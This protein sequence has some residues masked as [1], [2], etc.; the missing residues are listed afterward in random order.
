MSC[1]YYINDNLD[2]LP[3]HEQADHLKSCTLCR[4]R[5]EFED[6]IVQ[7]AGRLQPL[8]ADTALWKRIDNSIQAKNTSKGIHKLR[9]GSQSKI[10]LSAAAV[11][12]AV[13]TFSVFYIFSGGSEKILSDGALLRVEYTEQN[14]IAAIDQ[15]EKEATPKMAALD[16]DLMLLYRDKLETIDQQ[17]EQ[18][19]QAIKNNPGNAHIR[20]YMLA[21]LQDKKETL[22]EI[23]SI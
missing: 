11:I 13:F 20:R 21:A 4:E 15:L 16:L 23:L 7:E 2:T 6:K 14:Y 17:I 18:C 10:W 5:R 19:R 9:T 1:T 3:E 8:Q 12:I 22:Q